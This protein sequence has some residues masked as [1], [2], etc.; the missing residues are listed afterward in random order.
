MASENIGSLFNTK[1]PGY[2]D[3]ADIQAALRLYHYGDSSYDPENTDPLLLPSPSM[4]RHLQILTD[5]ITDLQN[6]G[7]GSVFSASEPTSPSN[8]FIWVDSTEDS[9]ISQN[10]FYQDEAPTTNLQNGMLWIDKDSVNV[11]LNVYDSDTASWVEV[12]V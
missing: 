12:G 2:E 5:N 3:A 6:V 8:G 7:P 1:M 4:A 9:P 11:S 10:V